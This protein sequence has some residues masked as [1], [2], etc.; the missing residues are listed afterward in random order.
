ME[1]GDNNWQM[2][3]DVDASVFMYLAW[4]QSAEQS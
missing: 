3:A 2:Q 4:K 1:D